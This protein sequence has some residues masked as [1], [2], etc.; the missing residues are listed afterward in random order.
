MPLQ[1]SPH[2]VLLDPIKPGLRVNLL[3]VIC[4]E[5]PVALQSSGRHQNEYA[6]GGLAEAE[7]FGQVFR[8]KADHQV[9]A[10][11]V[12]AVYAPQVFN[13]FFVRC[14]VL[15]LLRRRHINQLA[16]LVIT[17][18]AALSVSE[19]V[20]GGKVYERAVAAFESLEKARVVAQP[21][22]A[23]MRNAEGGKKGR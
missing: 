3:C 23:R 18:H 14:Q 7:S 20:Y 17:R 11:Y 21:D 12:V 5:E 16:K 4:G 8:V 22:C 6:K 9:N 2:I 13:P 15:E 1:D 10:V 19:H